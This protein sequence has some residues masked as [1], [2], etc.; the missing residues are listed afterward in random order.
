M[1][2]AI[3]GEHDSTAET[4]IATDRALAH[5]GAALGVEIRADWYS[6]AEVTNSL[7][8]GF[9]GLL[10]APGSPYRDLQKTIQAIRFARE[11]NLPC[12]GTCGGFQHMIIEFARHRLGIDD[13]QHGE[14][15][16]YSSRLIV[17]RL[18]CSLAGQQL[19]IRLAAGSR[20]AGLYGTDRAT[21]RYYCNFGLD[22][23]YV[24][25]FAEAEF[26]CVAVDA[27]GEVRAMEI[28]DHPFFLG[29][30]FVPQSRSTPENP[31]PIVTG[32]L[33]AV[34]KHRNG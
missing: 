28:T 13:A 14:Y 17:S 27:E 8:E 16:P 20:I 26:H 12:L 2:I 6:T 11:R 34:R 31:H 24:P 29:T 25:L 32:F 3:L 18:D 7:L 30:L 23:K 5:S 9:D 19:D 33:A 22:E 21:E 4:H 1:K 10:I 15:D